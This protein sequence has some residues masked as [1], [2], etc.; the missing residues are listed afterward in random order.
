MTNEETVNRC[1]IRIILFVGSET[2]SSPAAAQ[3]NLG[4]LYRDGQG[5][6]VAKDVLDGSN[7]TVEVTYPSNRL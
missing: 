7:R 5:A 4:V 1:R 6:G 3:T 2:A